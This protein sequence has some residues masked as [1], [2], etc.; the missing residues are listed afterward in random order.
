[1]KFAM[2]ICG[3]E[4]EWN[5]LPPA[6]EEDL[7]TQI[8]AW[9]ERWQPTGKIDYE[10]VELRH[11]R[12]ARTIRKDPDGGIVVTDGPYLELKEVIGGLLI[13]EA[14]S[15]EEAVEIASGWPITSGMSAVEVRPVMVRN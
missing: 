13:L 1:M 2:L 3:D 9:F 4:E 10:G 11:Q 12:T 8:H 6:E 5:A 15:I 7:M 14:D